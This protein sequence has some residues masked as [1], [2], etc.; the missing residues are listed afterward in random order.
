MASIVDALVVTLGLD[1]SRFTSGSK[2]ASADLRKTKED[3]NAAAKQIEASGRQAAEFFKRLRN[4]AIALF[5]TFT[6]GRGLAEFIRDITLSDAATGRL[7]HNLD[8]STQQLSAWEKA[9]E[10][11]GGSAGA[12]ASSFDSLTQQFQQFALTG[13]SSVIQYFRALN[14]SIS[15]AQ[16]HLRP[17]GDILLDLADKFKGMDPARAQ[18]FGRALGLDPGTITL[19]EQGRAAVAKLLAEKAKV[20]PTDADAG[21]A[22]GLIAQLQ[23]IR[24]QIDQLFR[25]ILNNLSPEISKLLA[26]LDDWLKKNKDWLAQNI[27]AELEKFVGWIKAIDWA[28][29]QKGLH[30][31]MSGTAGV[32][33]HLGGWIRVTETLFA[34]WL[35]AK[36]LAVMANLRLAAGMLTLGGAGGGAVGGLLGLLTKLLPLLATGAAGGEDPDFSKKKN[37]EFLSGRSG[38][39]FLSRFEKWLFGRSSSGPGGVLGDWLHRALGMTLGTVLRGGRPAS[40]GGGLRA[41]PASYTQDVPAAGGGGSRAPVSGM[42]GTLPAAGDARAAGIRDMLM[43]D[44]GLTREQAA[45]IVSNLQAESGLKGINERNPAVPGSR[46]GF[47][48]A[49]WTGPRRVAFEAWAKERKLDPSSDAA[50]YGFLLHELQTKYG[51]TLQAVRGAHSARDAAREFFHGYETG[52]AASLERWLGAHQQYADRFAG[53][54]SSRMAGLGRH[55]AGDVKHG[56]AKLAMHA[57]GNVSHTSNS[58]S[59]EVHLNGPIS[60]QTQATDARGVARG[61]GGALKEHLVFASQANYALA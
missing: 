25:T 3:A 7:A 22:Q 40:S 38:D 61:L 43:R 26:Q 53:L 4:E 47:G 1:A 42:G 8:M 57:R 17:L 54:P 33:T 30:D 29:V 6:A 12:T 15:D 36:F 16:G 50:N 35:G 27:S 55:P 56:G 32:I 45:G 21:R 9:A 18:A 52:G 59:S 19:L 20:S 48:W 11:V 58:S 37:D 31:F 2:Q 49:Q 39:D 44:L 46:G 28:A 14:V 13:Q 34:L 51:R 10:S 24:Q 5:A 23:D 60:V 41:T